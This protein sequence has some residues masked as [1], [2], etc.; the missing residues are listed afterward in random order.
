MP[1]ASRCARSNPA[2]T[3]KHAVRSARALFLQPFLKSPSKRLRPPISAVSEAL[4]STGFDLPS[5]SAMLMRS[6]DM[7]K[8]WLRIVSRGCGRKYRCITVVCAPMKGAAWAKTTAR[9][10]PSLPPPAASKISRIMGPVQQ[11]RGHA[12]TQRRM[13]SVNAKSLRRKSCA[14]L[15]KRYGA[16]PAIVDASKNSGMAVHFRCCGVAACRMMPKTGDVGGTRVD[17]A[18]REAMSAMNPRKR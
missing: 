1:C 3:F 7:P 5:A 6:S 8:G 14:N 13:R 11:V 4:A 10:A 2:V 12:S 17:M 16:A 9:D 15:S 18:R